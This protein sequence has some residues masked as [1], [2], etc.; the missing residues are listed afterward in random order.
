MLPPYLSNPKD[1][2][3]HAPFPTP[4]ACE[5]AFYDALDERDVARMMRVWDD[6]PDVACLLPMQPFIHGGQVRTLMADLLRSEAPLNIQVRH[7]QWVEIGDVAIHY[8]EEHSAMPGQRGP[9][10][11]LYATNVYR[12]RGEGGWTM[13]LHQNGPPA[14]RK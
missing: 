8:V 10:P 4:Q 12:R 3:M 9:V 14:P 1:P 13:I 5:D 6:A 7:V 11:P 2:P